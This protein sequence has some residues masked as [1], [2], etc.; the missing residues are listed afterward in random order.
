MPYVQVSGGTAKGKPFPM[1]GQCDICKKEDCNPI[2][3]GATRFGPWANMCEKCFGKVG[4][5]LGEGR[6]QRYEKQA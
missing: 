6:G 2:I 1:I 3:D 5:G 4:I